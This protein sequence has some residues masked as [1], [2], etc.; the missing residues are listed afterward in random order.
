MRELSYIAYLKQLQLEY[1]VAELR[2]CVYN[3]TSDKKYYRRVMSWKKKKIKDLEIRNSL[4]C[5]FTEPNKFYYKEG[6]R[7]Q[8][9]GQIYNEYGLPNFI[10]RDQKSKEQFEIQDITYYYSIG[11]KVQVIIDSDVIREGRIIGL[12]IDEKLVAVNLLSNNV[13]VD[14]LIE[15]SFDRV[16]RINLDVVF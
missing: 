6:L 1:I 3:S 13:L 4:P 7:K 14:Q 8:L 12:K 15:I 2:S 16:K 11:H 9:Y 5:I 10:Y